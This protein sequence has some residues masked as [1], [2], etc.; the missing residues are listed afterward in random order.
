MTGH[1]F[2]PRRTSH[3]NQQVGSAGFMNEFY[4][5]N[6]ENVLAEMLISTTVWG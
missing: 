3:C 4:K 5:A 1:L 6:W 2:T